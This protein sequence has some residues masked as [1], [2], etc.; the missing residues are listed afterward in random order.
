MARGNTGHV[1]SGTATDATTAETSPT[2]GALKQID[3][4]V[5]N[6]GY[7]EAGSE[8]G[9]A[10]LLLHGWPYDIHSYADVAP[11]LAAEGFRVLVPYLRGYGTT[12]FLSEETLRNGR[13]GSARSGCDRVPRRARSRAC[14]RCRLRLGCAHRGDRGGALARALPGA[15]LR[16]RLPDREPGGGQGAVAAGGGAPVVVPVL[17]RHRTRPRRLRQVPTRVREAD[18]AAR[19]AAVGLR[20]R[21]VRSER[22]GLR[23]PGSRRDRDSQLPLAARARPEGGRIRRARGAAR[24]WPGHHRAGDHARGRR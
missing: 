16:Q 11:L 24:G 9:P 13:A 15:R 5:L 8:D 20:R 3:A 7:V 2:F 10:V 19:L 14:G 4:G 6:V 17:L 23:Q 21:D 12:R 1:T 18:L 22:R